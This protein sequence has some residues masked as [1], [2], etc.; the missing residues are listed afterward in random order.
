MLRRFGYRQ[1]V[2]SAGLAWRRNERGLRDL[3]QEEAEDL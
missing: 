3:G 2:L 1:A